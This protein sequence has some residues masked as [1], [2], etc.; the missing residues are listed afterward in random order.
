MTFRW[1]A[2]PSGRAGRVCA[3][4]RRGTWPSPGARSPSGC[5]ADPPRDGAAGSFY[6]RVPVARH[7]R[8]QRRLERDPRSTWRAG[9]AVR[10]VGASRPPPPGDT[11]HLAW[12]PTFGGGGT[13]RLH[14]RR[15]RIGL[16][17]VAPL[18]ALERVS[19]AGAP[20]GFLLAVAARGQRR[21]DE[22]PSAPVVMTVP[23]GCTGP[24]GPP[25]NLLAYRP[26]APPSWCGIRRSRAGAV[27]LPA[28]GA[29]LRR[30]PA[31]AVRTISGPLGPGTYTFRCGRPA[32]AAPARGVAG[33]DGAVGRRW[34]HGGVAQNRKSR[35]ALIAS[36][37]FSERGKP[38][39]RVS[40]PS[41]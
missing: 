41:L 23:G 18:P 19:F 4:G 37:R 21:G 12:T 10:A 1:N 20:G 2:P 17:R 5:G 26:A 16:G 11:V 39:G 38:R 8:S 15:R 7:R 36:V 32:P 34:R 27:Q 24:T 31:G 30:I 35:V 13:R 28:L 22:R 29:R 6:V 25:T 40:R 14:A 9:A 3:R 33:P